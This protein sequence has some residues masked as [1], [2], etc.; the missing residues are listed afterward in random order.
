MENGDRQKVLQHRLLGI[1]PDYLDFQRIV[2][3]S[4][5]SHIPTA[6]HVSARD[7]WLKTWG[8]LMGD[9]FGLVHS[10]LLPG[11]RLLHS[12]GVFFFF[13]LLLYNLTVLAITSM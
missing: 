5:G 6:V 1:Y 11:D 8:A 10:P 4:S 2:A 13:F 9:N 3:W 12:H 7:P